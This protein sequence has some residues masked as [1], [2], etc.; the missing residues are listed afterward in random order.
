MKSLRK[1]RSFKKR[2]T[3]IVNKFLFLPIIFRG[4]LYWLESVK[5]VKA[6]NGQK[7]TIIGVDK[8]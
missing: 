5:L 7:T 3:H 2:H 6:F 8:F 1:K 4:K